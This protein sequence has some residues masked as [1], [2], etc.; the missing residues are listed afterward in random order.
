MIDWAA[1]ARNWM[2]NANKFNTHENP[3][4]AK[5]LNTPTDKD[6]SEPL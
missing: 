1:A 5:H 6:Y 4:G 3:N 2:L